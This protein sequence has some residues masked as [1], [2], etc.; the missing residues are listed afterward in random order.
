MKAKML[1]LVAVVLFALG[2]GDS[3]NPVAPPPPLHDQYDGSG[4]ECHERLYAGNPRPP[5][6]DASLL[7]EQR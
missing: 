6:C 3:W 5:H 4:P 7:E 1:A 2:C